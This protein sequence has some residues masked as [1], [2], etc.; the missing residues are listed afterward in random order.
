MLKREL[1]LKINKGCVGC[2]K[3]CIYRGLTTTKDQEDRG[4]YKCNV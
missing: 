4:K 1:E 3:N 2:N